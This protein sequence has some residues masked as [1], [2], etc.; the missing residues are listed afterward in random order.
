MGLF[1]DK[2]LDSWMSLSGFDV[3][4]ASKLVSVGNLGVRLQPYFLAI[5]LSFSAFRPS[6]KMAKTLSNGLPNH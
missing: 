3:E 4:L 2:T 6:Q 1:S 5:R